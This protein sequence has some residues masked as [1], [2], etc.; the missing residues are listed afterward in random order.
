MKIIRASSRTSKPSPADHFTGAA[1]SDEIVV[2]S[3]PSRM[4][5]SIVSFT[6]GARTAWHSHALGQTLYCV[7][8]V[9]RVQVEGEPVQ[10]LRPGDTAVIPPNR[11]HWHGAAP[12]RM[13]AHLAMS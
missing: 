6:P 11:N 3:A 13:F 8:G 12:G 4:R 9:G 7:Y 2:G 5:A 10:E 1:F